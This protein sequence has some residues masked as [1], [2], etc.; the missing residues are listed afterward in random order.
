MCCKAIYH[1]LL[2]LV[3]DLSNYIQRHFGEHLFIT[4]LENQTLTDRI[5]TN[6]YLQ[7][8]PAMPSKSFTLPLVLFS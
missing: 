7:I 8:S 6:K 2:L 5:Q 1:T 3:V 4:T